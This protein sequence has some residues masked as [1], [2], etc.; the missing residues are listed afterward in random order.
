VSRTCTSGVA[1]ADQV[2]NA[3]AT[4]VSRPAAPRTKKA[5]RGRRAVGAL[6]SG[7]PPCSATAAT[8]RSMAATRASSDVARLISSCSSTSSDIGAPCTALSRWQAQGVWG[9]ASGVPPSGNVWV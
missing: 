1:V 9:P 5:T 2:L 3:P 4:K 6:T 7:V 8:K